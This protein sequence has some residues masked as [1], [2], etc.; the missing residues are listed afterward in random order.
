ML[1]YTAVL[2]LF[3]SALIAHEASAQPL[4]DEAVLNSAVE[5][6]PTSANSTD[7]LEGFNRFIFKVNDTLDAYFLVPVAKGYRNSLPKPSRT[8]VY[9]F[10]SNITQ[11]NTGVQQVLQG[12]I[13][14][15]GVSIAR[16]L[17]NT[18][19]GF[20]GLFDPASDMGLTREQEDFGQTLGVWGI[21]PGPYVVL[22]FLGPST[23]RDGLARLPSY[24]MSIESYTFTTNETWAFLLLDTLAFRESLLGAE[25]IFSG[26]RYAAFRDA[27]LS[28]RQWQ[29]TDGAATEEDESI[30]DDLF[31]EEF[32]EEDFLHHWDASSLDIAS[33]LFQK[34]PQ[35]ATL[36]TGFPYP[37]RL[38]PAHRKQ[39]VLIQQTLSLYESMV[40]MPLVNVREHQTAVEPALDAPI[41]PERS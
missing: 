27:Y 4:I 30:L 40:A 25:K 39:Q 8:G 20:G 37:L 35:N 31:D 2:V 9:N 24:F 23:L 1:I 5:S 32:D 13:A 3:A 26:D 11:F 17:I 6:Q 21:G 16:F 19:L 14:K 15:S 10:T 29:V 7:P 36:D 33:A 12:K 41:W 38:Y 28:R 22:P 34:Q 18:F